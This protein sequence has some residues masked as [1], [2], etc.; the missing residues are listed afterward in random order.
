MKDADATREEIRAAVDAL[1]E[2]W[3][4]E[5]PEFD[6]RK[7]VVPY[8]GDNA[9]AKQSAKTL[10]TDVGCQP[11]DVGKLFFSR[12]LESSA[13]ILSSASR[14]LRLPVGPPQ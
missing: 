2:E 14:L 8:C 13:R 5:R 1:F 10:I 9:D 12:H 7:L 3:G 11:M 6:G 4:I